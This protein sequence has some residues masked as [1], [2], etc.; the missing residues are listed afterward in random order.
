MNDLDSLLDILVLGCGLYCIYLSY[1]MKVKGSISNP[2]LF[3]NPVKAA[4]C[5]DKEGYIAYMLPRMLLFGV[6]TTLYGAAGLVNTYVG[7][8]GMVYAVFTLA[9]LIALIWFFTGARKAYRKFF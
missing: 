1:K 9:F 4:Q 2:I 3:S 7:K 8:L 6:F 5:K